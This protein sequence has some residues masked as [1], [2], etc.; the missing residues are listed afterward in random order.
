MHSQLIMS[1]Q[2]Y[3]V[4]RRILGKIHCELFAQLICNSTLFSE[5][6]T[7]PLRCNF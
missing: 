3:D 1:L 2:N 7:I 4:C 6:S 5:P